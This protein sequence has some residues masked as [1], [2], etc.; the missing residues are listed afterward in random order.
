MAKKW[1][2]GILLIGLFIVLGFAY[3][4]LQQSGFLQSVQP[5]PVNPDF[6]TPSQGQ[7][8]SLDKITIY[9]VN[10]DG[11]VTSSDK[12]IASVV[13]N[14][15]NDRLVGSFSDTAVQGK[16]DSADKQEYS[17]LPKNG[18]QIA[19]YQTKET[20]QYLVIAD[21]SSTAELYTLDFKPMEKVT[22]HDYLETF[23]IDGSLQ[24]LF[25]YTPTPD[26]SSYDSSCWSQ[27]GIVFTGGVAND[28]KSC[29][30]PIKTPM[31]RLGREVRQNVLWN[32]RLFIRTNDG[33][34]EQIDFGW[35]NQSAQSADG[36]VK[37]FE[38]GGLSRGSPLSSDWRYYRSEGFPIWDAASRAVVENYRTFLTTWESFY[39]NAINDAKMGNTKNDNYKLTLLK[40]NKGAPSTLDYNNL[41]DGTLTDTAGKSI[42]VDASHSPTGQALNVYLKAYSEG[43]YYETPYPLQNHLIKIEIDADWMGIMRLQ[44]KPESVACQDA[45]IHGDGTQGLIVASVR[46]G[47]AAGSITLKLSCPQAQVNPTTQEIVINQGETKQAQFPVKKSITTQTTETCTVYAFTGAQGSTDTISNT[48]SLTTTPICLGVQIPLGSLYELNGDTCELVCPTDKLAAFCAASGLQVGS[49]CKCA[50]VAS[51]TPTVSPSPSGSP[52]PPPCSGGECATSECNFFE[53]ESD[54]G[55]CEPNLPI[56]AGVILLVLGGL[57]LVFQKPIKKWLKKR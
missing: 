24:S 10:N 40:A 9:D 41:I 4:A 46:N 12:F 25:S 50:G 6:S 54:A 13:L 20:V 33:K 49:G 31:A 26:G 32:A 39:L 1:N 22:F 11:V 14:G 38:L 28:W 48:C 30:L 3:F 37:V 34:Q 7:A 19:F 5:L 55:G 21:T 44:P 53:K 17:T 47:G 23:T 16:T 52:T 2:T 36:K 57:G 45:T 27:G 43:V 15:G 51:P 35:Q 42:M 29:T 18:F 56:V 8:I